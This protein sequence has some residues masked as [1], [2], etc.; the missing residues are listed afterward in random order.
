MAESVDESGGHRQ[1]TGAL[2]LHR[3][4]LIEVRVGPLGGKNE[5]E[6][7]ELVEERG[8]LLVH[9]LVGQKE[10]KLGRNRPAV[11]VAYAMHERFREGDHVREYEGAYLRRTS[12]HRDRAFGHLHNV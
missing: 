5:T 11:L 8:G 1:G 6:C 10:R 7:V 4:R 3:Y 9:G 2:R 12:E